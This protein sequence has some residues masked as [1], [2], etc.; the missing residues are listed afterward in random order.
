MIENGEGNIVI[1]EGTVKNITIPSTTT[2]TTRITAEIEDG[3][4]ISSEA[5]KLLYL[6]NT[7]EKPVSMSLNAP[8]VSTIY[9]TGE[10]DTVETNASIKVSTGEIREVVVSKEGN[11]TI[12]APL[13][14]ADAKVSSQEEGSITIT[15]TNPGADLEIATPSSTVTL[16][17]TYGKVKSEVSDSTL[18]IGPAAKIDRL[19]V[20]KGN[21]VVN[22]TK[23]ENRISDISN[24]T[25]YTVSCRISEVSDWSEFSK[26]ATKPG[27]TIFTGNIEKA[28]SGITFGVVASGNYEWNLGENTLSCGGRNG[29]ILTRGS[30]NL[31]LRNGNLE[32]SSYGVWCSGG[33]INLYDFNVSGIT[34]AVYCEK[35]EI[36][37]Y[38]GEYRISDSD[39]T[40][41]VNCLDANYKNGTA[42]INIYGGT[43]Y[44][45]N[46]AASMGEPGGPVSFVA[47]GYKVQE[48]EEGI[49][50][51]MKHENY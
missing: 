27:F 35:G 18:Y 15:N 48:I 10:Y 39:K 42:K 51:V 50:K 9:L 2:I 21:V 31:T 24:D 40:F 38:G 46:P 13:R 37:I 23:V 6:N 47:K 36:N 17:G 3:A 25:E 16:N 26:S 22:D 30:V 8:S 11:T 49:Y 41:L 28:G 12:N 43:F 4:T 45:W 19:V 44:G 5:S 32:S 14:G 7:S 33:I 1:P 34:H 29:A 20:L